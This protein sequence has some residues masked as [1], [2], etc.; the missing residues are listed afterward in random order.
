VRVN[1]NYRIAGMY[2]PILALSDN[3]IRVFDLFYAPGHDIIGFQVQIFLYPYYSQ[4][5]CVYFIKVR[6]QIIHTPYLSIPS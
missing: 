1:G 4:R 6:R 2:I 5:G 3:I